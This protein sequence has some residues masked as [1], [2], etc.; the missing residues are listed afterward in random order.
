M[1]W[2]VSSSGGAME[3][4]RT[5]LYL[6][7]A[8]LF[9]VGAVVFAVRSQGR[10]APSGRSWSVYLHGDWSAVS[11]SECERSPGGRQSADVGG[12]QQRRPDRLHRDRAARDPP[13]SP[14]R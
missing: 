10:G 5:V 2:L 4:V 8:V 12:E 14:R 7:L 6:V 9:P 1:L 13:R 11:G 3:I